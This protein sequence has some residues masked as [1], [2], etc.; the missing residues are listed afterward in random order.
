MT[1]SD[2]D[3]GRSRRPGG[4]DQEWSHRSVLELIKYRFH[5]PTC[6]VNV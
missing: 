4:E 2:E 1:D 3:H 5:A 6:R